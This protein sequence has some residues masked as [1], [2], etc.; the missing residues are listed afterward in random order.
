MAKR[1]KTRDPL[2]MANVQLDKAAKK[3]G[4][5]SDT[6]E[7]LRHPKR[8]LIV[9]VPIKLDSGETKVFQ[10]YRV[11][12]NIALGP[13]KGGT[14]YFT[15]VTIN[16]VRARAMWMTWKCSVVGIPYG[17]AAGGIRCN[18]KEMSINELEHMTRRYISEISMK[19]RGN[20]LK[21]DGCHTGKLSYGL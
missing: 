7:M 10:G 21:C 16:E 20:P 14:R 6:L 19:F 17:G 15:D 18:P 11:Q 2:D 8:Q 13:T 9:S 3:M 12:H 5:G 4:L 1:G